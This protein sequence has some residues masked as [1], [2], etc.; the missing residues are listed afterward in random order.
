MTFKL[1]ISM[2]FIF[3]IYISALYNAA[4]NNNLDVIYYLLM[5]REKIDHEFFIK[6]EKLTKVVIPTTIKSIGQFAF[7]KCLSLSYISIDSSLKSIENDVFY[8]CSSLT[9]I[10]IPSSVTSIGKESF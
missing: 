2:K 1:I 5:K 10:K 3:K 9:K 6:C 8:K 7:Y 4:N